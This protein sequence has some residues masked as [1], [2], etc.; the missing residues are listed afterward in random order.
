MLG[1]ENIIKSPALPKII[2]NL[3]S[4]GSGAKQGIGVLKTIQLK[5]SRKKSD[6]LQLKIT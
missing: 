6:K 4:S 5:F 3:R 2:R 1:V